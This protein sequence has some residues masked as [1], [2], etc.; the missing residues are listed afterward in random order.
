MTY[1]NHALVLAACMLAWPAQASAQTFTNVTTES[2]AA[3]V[4][5]LRPSGW[6]L[7][8]FQFVDW[9]ATAIS[10]SAWARTA[11]ATASSR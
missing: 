10:T 6:W 3:A 4:R 8:G 7:S 11:A 1:R 5:A 2:G 9:T